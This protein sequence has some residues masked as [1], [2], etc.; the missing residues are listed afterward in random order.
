MHGDSKLKV[1]CWSLNLKNDQNCNDIKDLF[2]VCL[3]IVIEISCSLGRWA[4][5]L[6]YIICIA[7]SD[8]NLYWY[9]NDFHRVC[10][11]I[12]YDAFYNDATHL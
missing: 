7:S 6:S 11:I 3:H 2:I 9:I 8:I 1:L 12:L 4:T 5:C 10:M